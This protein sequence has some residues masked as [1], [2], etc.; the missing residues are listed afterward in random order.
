MSKS[1]LP[2]TIPDDIQWRVL[3]FLMKLPLPMRRRCLAITK[4]N[5]V[6]K[7]TSTMNIYCCHHQNKIIEA[8]NS[9][10]FADSLIVH[11]DYLKRLVPKNKTNPKIKTKKFITDYYY[12][13]Y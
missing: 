11:Y 12:G 8:I 6:C 1:V 7:K 13:G 5:R 9:P 4:S 3:S 2:R 10:Y